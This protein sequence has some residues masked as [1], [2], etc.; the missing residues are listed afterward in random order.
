MLEPQLACHAVCILSS[1]AALVLRLIQADDSQLWGSKAELVQ[2]GIMA[3]AL[4]CRLLSFTLAAASDTDSSA[5]IAAE[6]LKQTLTSALP[7]MLEHDSCASGFPEQ[8]WMAG[9][10]AAAGN[11]LLGQHSTLALA[12]LDASAQVRLQGLAHQVQEGKQ[13]LMVPADLSPRVCDVIFMLTFLHPISGALAPEEFQQALQLC[14][15]H[16]S[17]LSK[18]GLLHEASTAGTA[19]VVKLAQVMLYV[20]S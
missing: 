16:V 20:A 1:Q 19:H 18:E 15:L 5:D 11:E 10:M 13:E 3:T 17:A 14:R 4:A 7:M 8:G 9:L 6:A 2:D 12:M